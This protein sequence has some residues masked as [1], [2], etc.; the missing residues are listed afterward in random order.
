MARW[1]GYGGLIYFHLLL[2][3]LATARVLSWKKGRE[4]ERSIMA[5]A[6]EQTNSGIGR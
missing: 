2:D 3:R 5:H 4:E 1:K 6:P